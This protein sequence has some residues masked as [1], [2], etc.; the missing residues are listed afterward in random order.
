ML[1]DCIDQEGMDKLQQLGSTS[2]AQACSTWL[3]SVIEDL[4]QQLP[5]LLAGCKTAAQLTQLEAAVHE[6]I[7]AWHKPVMTIATPGQALPASLH[8][9]SKQSSTV[10]PFRDGYKTPESSICFTGLTGLQYPV[11]GFRDGLLPFPACCCMCGRMKSAGKL[12]I[13]QASWA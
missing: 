1:S 13:L 6:G 3:S 10:V 12:G 5:G 2:M 8:V 4:Q 9:C 7:A 11:Y